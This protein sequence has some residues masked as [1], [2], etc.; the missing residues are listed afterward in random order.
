MA[1][2]GHNGNDHLNRMKIFSLFVM[3]LICLGMS[4]CILPKNLSLPDGH[5]EVGVSKVIPEDVKLHCGKFK[6]KKGKPRYQECL[7][8]IGYLPSKKNPKSDAVT[9]KEGELAALIG[10]PTRIIEGKGNNKKVFIYDLKL[11]SSFSNGGELIV[12][13]EAGLVVDSVLVD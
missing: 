7:K 9:L 5:N 12:Y 2:F 3:A 8:F 13:F 11:E 1:T 4:G 10:P 6:E